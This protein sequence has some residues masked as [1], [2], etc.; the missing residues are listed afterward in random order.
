MAPHNSLSVLCT[1]I[2]K[3]KSLTRPLFL[4]ELGYKP[5]Q[6]NWGNEWFVSTY[7]G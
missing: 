2:A 5:T 3:K 7:L 6:L 4:Q 1:N